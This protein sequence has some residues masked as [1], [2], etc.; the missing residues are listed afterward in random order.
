MFKSLRLLLN[1]LLSIRIYFLTILSCAINVGGFN[2]ECTF[3]TE[4]WNFG[5]AGKTCYMKNVVV[6]APNQ[7]VTSVNSRSGLKDSEVKLIRADFQTINF[8]PSGIEKYFPE[9]LGVAI[10]NCHLKSIEK[11][12]LKTFDKLIYL[13]IASNDLET[14]PNDLFEFHTELRTIQA[15]NNK[16]KYV[17][18]NIF[19]QLKSLQYAQ[20]SNNICINPDDSLSHQI[21]ALIQELK[22]KCPMKLSPLQECQRN[23]EELEEEIQK[24]KAQVKSLKRQLYSCSTSYYDKL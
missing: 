23:S 5:A 3:G 14:L 6:T 22:V 4:D 21:P 7:M 2:L 8:I 13:H 19:A 10:M 24:L 16:L 15:Y 20:F 1:F 18:E 17:G 12:D 9:L 11:S